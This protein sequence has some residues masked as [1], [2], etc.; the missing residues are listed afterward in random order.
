M[1]SPSQ[2]IQ[3]DESIKH[4][5]DIKSDSYVVIFDGNQYDSTYIPALKQHIFNKYTP[6]TIGKLKIH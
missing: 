3:D 4:I 1:V 5:N 6:E 2:K